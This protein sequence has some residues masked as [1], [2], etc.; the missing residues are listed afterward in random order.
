MGGGESGCDLLGGW[1][2]DMTGGPAVCVWGCGSGC[3]GDGGGG[4]VARLGGTRN[5]RRNVL[6]PLARSCSFGHCFGS[7]RRLAPPLRSEN[8]GTLLKG[9][10]GTY[11]DLR[12]SVDADR[13]G[14]LR[15]SA[16]AA[17]SPP[18]CAVRVRYLR[19][20]LGWRGER[21]CDGA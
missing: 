11:L 5:L 4:G 6:W 21:R 17:T 13:R 1:V 7:P 9:P 20:G 19:V 12:G 14:Q 2:S 18:Y 8:S 10:V 15:H 3:R 16:A